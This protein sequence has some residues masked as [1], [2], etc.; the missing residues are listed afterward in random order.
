MSLLA[1]TK[2]K[3]LLPG[4]IWY[5]KG[6]GQCRISRVFRAE[7]EPGF[8]WDTRC[9]TYRVVSDERLGSFMAEQSAFLENA[10]LVVE[11]DWS[12]FCAYKAW[13]SE[14]KIRRIQ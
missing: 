12:E 14:N 7:G 11:E 8:A 5:V 2:S 6:I 10:E 3:K 1:P 4:Q 13:M 9:L